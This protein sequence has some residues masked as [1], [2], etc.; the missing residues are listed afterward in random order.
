MLGY[1]KN[2]A[3]KIFF[4]LIVFL[5]MGLFVL[6]FIKY[7][8]LQRKRKTSQLI[9]TSVQMKKG[10]KL[11]CPTYKFSNEMNQTE[12]F[13]QNA[14]ALPQR[15]AILRRLEVST[16]TMYQVDENL[17]S[18]MSVEGFEWLRNNNITGFVVSQNV[19]RAA[20]GS[21]S[22]LQAPSYLEDKHCKVNQTRSCI[23]NY[24]Y[25]DFNFL[26]NTFENPFIL[27]VQFNLGSSFL[28]NQF[29]SKHPQPNA[30]YSTELSDECSEYM[31]TLFYSEL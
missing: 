10:P 29:H 15:Q 22:T 1:S 17:S 24:Q 11:V 5:C 28:R 23:E 12:L 26:L 18:K 25:N 7:K 14:I 30:M 16:V 4:I 19:S 21:I 8:V 31:K 13:R 9:K 3:L 27:R 6:N 20:I 2:K